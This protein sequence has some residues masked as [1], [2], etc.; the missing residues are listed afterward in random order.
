[1]KARFLFVQRCVFACEFDSEWFLFCFLT[2]GFKRTSGVFVALLNHRLR[3]FRFSCF[4]WP[5][6]SPQGVSF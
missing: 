3:A 6:Q 4:R 1:M 5:K 2:S